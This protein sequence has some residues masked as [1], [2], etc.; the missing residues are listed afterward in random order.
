M[1][2]S[3]LFIQGAKSGGKTRDEGL[4]E[5]AHRAFEVRF[6]MPFSAARRFCM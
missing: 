2:P 4:I 6:F 5:C 1:K 3:N